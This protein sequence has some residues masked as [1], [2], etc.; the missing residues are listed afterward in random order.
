LVALNYRKSALTIAQLPRRGEALSAHINIEPDYRLRQGKIIGTL[1]QL[2][3]HDYH[4]THTTMQGECSSC[5]TG[6][7]I[8]KLK[9]R[10]RKANDGYNHHSH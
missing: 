6:P 4:I 1:E 7:I 8:Q 9:H 5:L 3:D 2:L 10:P